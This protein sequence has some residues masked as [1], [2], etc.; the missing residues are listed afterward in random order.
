MYIFITAVQI[1]SI[2]ALSLYPVLSRSAYSAIAE[3]RRFQPAAQ[4]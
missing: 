1:Y 4:F 2:T 3:C